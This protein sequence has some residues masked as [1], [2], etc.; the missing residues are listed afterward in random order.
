MYGIVPAYAELH[1]LSNFSFLRGA[2][3]PGELIERAYELGYSALAI[4]DE[5]SVAGVV[6]A[7]EAA[8]ACKEAAKREI[9]PRP[10]LKL[11]IGSEITLEDGLKL[12]LLATDRASYGR[13]TSLITRGRMRTEKG[14]Y[15]LTRDDLDD[16][17]GCIALLVAGERCTR[18]D[19]SFVRERFPGRAWIAA[20]LLRGPNDR[21]RLDQLRALAKSAG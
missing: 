2:S 9:P 16:V 5:C 1:C 10:A 21:A 19:A 18:E 8:R 6:R 11:I 15:R 13:L 4:T 12:V 7:Y 17:H 20:E 14:A 3:H